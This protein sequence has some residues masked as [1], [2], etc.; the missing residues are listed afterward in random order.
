MPRPRRNGERNPSGKLKHANGGP[1]GEPVDAIAKW[2]RQRKLVEHEIVDR[3]WVRRSASSTDSASCRTSNWAP[4]SA[5]PISRAGRAGPAGRHRRPCAQLP[6]IQQT[7]SGASRTRRRLATA[8]ALPS[9]SSRPHGAP[10]QGWPRRPPTKPST[11]SLCATKR[12]A[13]LTRLWHLR[14]AARRWQGIGAASV[15]QADPQ[16]VICS[17]PAFGGA[18]AWSLHMLPRSPA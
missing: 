5:S 15:R 12:Q 7:T 3:R 14:S 13:A 9:R 4:V 11:P 8:S 16:V 10:S 6:M 1:N 18:W 17:S 2:V